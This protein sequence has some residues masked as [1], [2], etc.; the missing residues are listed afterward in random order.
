MYRFLRAEADRAGGRY[1]DALRNYEALL[2][3]PQW[4]GLRDR[5][6]FGTADAHVRAGEFDEA[7]KWLDTLKESF[8]RYFER[9][10]VAEYQKRVE[11]RRDREKARAAA[12]TKPPY[13]DRFATG[14]E[15]DESEYSGGTTAHLVYP[16]LGLFGNSAL[17]I[18][19]FPAYAGYGEFNRPLADL[20]TD[21]QY[22]VEFWYR[23][24]MAP[25]IG[26]NTPHAHVWIVGDGEAYNGNVGHATVYFER[27]LGRWRK[28]GFKLK[29]PVNPDG[30]LKMS[31]RLV[32]GVMQIDGLRV[33][34]V[35][36]RESDTL[37][38][39]IEGTEDQ[40]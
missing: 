30:S 1:A 16:A 31:I 39:F 4:A 36:D 18:N 33:V 23:D 34:P 7:L 28:L 22:W 6:L 29:G 12:T 15:P 26:T 21:G 25:A 11:V 20:N 38:N 2:R 32:Y 40:P 10:K 17:M 37:L 14:F 8:P 5:A 27:T 9:E 35:S 19:A 13:S 24:T 3:L